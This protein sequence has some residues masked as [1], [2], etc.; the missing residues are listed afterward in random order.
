MSSYLRDRR[1]ELGLTMKQVAEAV[2]VSEATVSRWESGDIQNMKSNRIAAMAKV[3][4]TDPNF[5]MTGKT[6]DEEMNS[7]DAELA[8]YLEYLK[9]RPEMRM[10]FSL[11]K[12][13]TKAEVEKAV[14]IIEAALSK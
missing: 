9:T 14:R 6:V 2:G 10:L 13:A 4:Q 1:Q 8:E 3:L 5:V 12:N 11:T 7:E